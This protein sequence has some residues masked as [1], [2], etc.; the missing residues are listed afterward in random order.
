[1]DVSDCGHDGVI[2][3]AVFCLAGMKWAV[4]LAAIPVHAVPVTTR[5]TDWI[6]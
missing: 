5:K 4:S 1:M 2:S 3:P 6:S